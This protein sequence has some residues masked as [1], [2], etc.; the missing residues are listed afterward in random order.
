[1]RFFRRREPT[2]GPAPTSQAAPVVRS[3]PDQA[4]DFSYVR[5]LE[6]LVDTQASLLWGAGAGL[7]CAVGVGVYLVATERVQVVFTQFDSEQKMMVR[8]YSD[9]TDKSVRRQLTENYLAEYVAKR[10]A[11]DN[12]TEG[13]R[14][15][16]LRVFTHPEYFARFEGDMTPNNPDSPLIQFGKAPGGPV[17]REVFVSNVTPMA[18]DDGAYQIEYT[19]I[20]RQKGREIARAAWFVSLRILYRNMTGKKEDIARNPIGLT[21]GPY[22]RRARTLTDANHTRAAQEARQ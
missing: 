20:D 6:R 3:N 18:G 8:L 17:A 21:V 11:I 5:R 2:L 1:M 13:A 15:D 4:D 10:E 14:Y 7:L 12:T 9:L 22:E 16:W 19:T